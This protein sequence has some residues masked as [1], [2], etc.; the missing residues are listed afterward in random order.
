MWFGHLALLFLLMNQSLFS[1]QTGIDSLEKYFRID[2][3]DDAS[4]IYSYFPPIFIQNGIELKSFVRS[5]IISDIR[6]QFSD[7]QS[8]DAIY[9]QAMKL[10]NNN[11]AISLLIS[12]LAC[13][14]HRLVGLKVP[15][16]AL[17][18]PLTNESEEEFKARVA[19]LPRYLYADSPKNKIGDRDKLQHFFGSAFLTFIFESKS[20]AEELSR[21]IEVG[22][23]AIIVDGALDERDMRANRHGQNFGLALIQN[24]FVLP[25]DYFLNIK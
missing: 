22:E 9:I 3:T 13:F 19:N 11:T 23:D 5:N 10:T 16:F 15:V 1:Q 8:V 25:S 4:F 24:K 21:S 7:L 2:S 12:T 6:R 17:Y 18:F 14:D 20:P